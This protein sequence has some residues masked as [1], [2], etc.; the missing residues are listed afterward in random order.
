MRTIRFKVPFLS[1]HMVF[2][3][4]KKDFQYLIPVPVIAYSDKNNKNSPALNRH[5]AQG[6]I[7]QNAQMMGR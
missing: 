4:L 1:S 2:S 6:V 5:R 7:R 3:S